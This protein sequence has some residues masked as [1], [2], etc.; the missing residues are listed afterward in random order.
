MATPTRKGG[1]M[2]C[3]FFSL[4]K[5]HNK[6]C[7]LTTFEQL[8]KRSFGEIYIKGLTTSAYMD[9]VS[10]YLTKQVKVNVFR[11]IKAEHHN[12]SNNYYRKIQ[13]YSPLLMVFLSACE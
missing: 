2:F 4:Y 13:I 9:L 5:D 10:G 1:S 8:S 3:L 12:K 11:L 6:E 7:P